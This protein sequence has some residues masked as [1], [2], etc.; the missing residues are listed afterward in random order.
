MNVNRVIAGAT[1]LLLAFTAGATAFPSATLAD[2]TAT[3]NMDRRAAITAL[4]GR[5]GLRS[6]VVYALIEAGKS[7]GE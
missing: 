2:T 6:R 1:S 5:Y 4:A 7:S 3:G